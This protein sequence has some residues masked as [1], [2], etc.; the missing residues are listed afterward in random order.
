MGSTAI[1]HII[2]VLSLHN[3]IEK[4]CLKIDE[5]KLPLNNGQK[6][7]LECIYHHYNELKLIF[8]KEKKTRHNHLSFRRV[9]NEIDLGSY[10]Y[11]AI[12]YNCKLQ[13]NDNQITIKNYSE[14]LKEE[15]RYFLCHSDLFI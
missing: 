12:F 7:I 3:N 8:C 15:T 11:V 5:I 13:N 14:I 1:V 4:F 6:Y 2:K 9:Y 10:Y